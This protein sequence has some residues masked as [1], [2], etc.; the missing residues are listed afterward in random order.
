M[1]VLFPLPGLVPSGVPATLSLPAL[2][3]LRKCPLLCE[4]S[5]AHSVQDC[6]A[7]CPSRP[8]TLIIVSDPYPPLIH[9]IFSC[10]FFLVCPPWNIN[11]TRVGTLSCPLLCP[12][13]QNSR[14][15]TAYS[16][17]K[18]PERLNPRSGLYRWKK[19]DLNPPN[20]KARLH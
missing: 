5:H 11:S 19:W 18:Q 10:F 4:L 7:P 1:S 20:G 13:I 9:W 6:H 14:G 2:A 12:C 3:S 17:G 15:Q 16:T 8:P